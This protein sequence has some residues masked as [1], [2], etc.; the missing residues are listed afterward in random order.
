M[1]ECMVDSCGLNLYAT[2]PSPTS[3]PS[4]VITFGKTYPSIDLSHLRVA[5]YQCR[6]ANHFKWHFQVA[7][8]N[9]ILKEPTHS[10]FITNVKTFSVVYCALFAAYRAFVWHYLTNQTWNLMGMLFTG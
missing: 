3:C 10:C 1:V 8:K 7:V 5:F 4:S 9:C 2:F 6:K